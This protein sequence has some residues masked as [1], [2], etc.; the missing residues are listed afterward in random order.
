MNLRDHAESVAMFNLHDYSGAD[1]ATAL[2]EETNRVLQ[3]I[4]TMQTLEFSNG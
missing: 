1:Y 4:T 3:E 2:L